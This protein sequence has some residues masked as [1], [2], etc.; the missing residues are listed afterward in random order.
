MAKHK[1]GQ[2]HGGRVHRIEV[3]M[4]GADGKGSG[5]TITHHH[6]QDDKGHYKEPTTHIAT[7]HGEVMDHLHEHLSKSKS[8]IET[9]E[10]DAG[11][12]ACVMCNAGGE[13]GKTPREEEEDEESV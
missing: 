3:E 7:H 6:V 10:H 13:Y 9:D 4:H 12:K 11:E 2:H 1:S 8:D 5:Y